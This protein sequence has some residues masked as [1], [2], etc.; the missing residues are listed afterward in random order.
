MEALLHELG[1][2]EDRLEEIVEVVRDA[3]GEL[4]QGRELL[5]LVQLFLDLA[6][7]R[8]VAD[9]RDQ[10]LEPAMASVQ[11]RERHCQLDRAR[12]PRGGRGL[13]LVPR[14]ALG[15]SPSGVGVVSAREHVRDGAADRL[16]GA[17]AEDAL[18]RRVPLLDPIVGRNRD[19]GLAGGRNGL[20]EPLLRVGDLTVE[21]GITQGDRQVLREHLEELTLSR[22]D[23]APRGPVVDDE[24]SKRPLHVADDAR[25]DARI[26]LVDAHR[27]FGDDLD[28]VVAEGRPQLLGDC[29]GHVLGVEVADDRPRDLPEDRELG[30]AEGLLGGLGLLEL[31]G[32]GGELAHLLDEP[33]DLAAGAE[34]GLPAHERAMDDLLEILAREGLDEVLERSVRERVADGLERRVRRDHHDLDRRVGALDVPEQLEPVHLGHLDIHDHDVRLEPTKQIEGRASVLRRLDRVAGLEQHPQRLAGTQLV[35]DDENAPERGGGRAHGL[36]S[37]SVT[38]KWSSWRP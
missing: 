31:P 18:G 2:A 4:S 11:R 22:I 15:Q 3:A 1:V 9:D 25:H 17:G 23:R 26:V 35:V 16:G 36:A 37:G 33:R 14:R 6:L 7:G 30:D 20:L 38:R 21:T 13:E 5:G 32:L 8:D 12:L 24:V 19:D 34:V 29:R 10:P 27:V 28:A